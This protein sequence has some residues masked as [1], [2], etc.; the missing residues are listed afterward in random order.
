MIKLFLLLFRIK[1]EWIFLIFASILG[2][3]CLFL[4]PYGESPDEQSHFYRAYQIADGVFIPLKKGTSKQMQVG[5]EIP[6]SIAKTFSLIAIKGHP[7]HNQCKI[8]IKSYREALKLKLNPQEKYFDSSFLNTVLYSPIAYLPAAIGIKIGV[9][10]DF[11]P[12][13]IMYLGR[14]LNLFC[15][16]LIM[17]F[18]I[19]TTPILKH[20][21]LAISILP[22]IIFE[23]GASV[24][25]DAFLTCTSMFFLAYVWKLSYGTNVR[26]NVKV[27]RKKYINSFD[28]FI[29]TLTGSVIALIKSFY[30]PILLSVFLIPKKYFKNNKR[31]LLSI[32]VI[33]FV[34]LLLS[35][36]WN[37][38]A[39][40]FYIPAAPDIIPGLQ[41][42][43]MLAHPLIFFSHL[44]DTLKLHIITTSN[45]FH[46][47][48]GILGWL[49]IIFPEEVYSYALQI[50]LFLT[51]TDARLINNQNED[52]VNY[53]FNYK[54]KIKDKIK[55]KWRDKLF[56]FALFVG[57]IIL[58]HVVMYLSW[59]PVGS[60][61]IIIG[62]QCRYLYPF[63]ICS[64]FI[65]YNRISLF[66]FIGRINNLVAIL[67]ASSLIIKLIKV[68]FV[69]YF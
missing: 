63:A 18:A 68:L 1:V 24:S 43:Y 11:P 10:F 67:F 65:F 53:E 20:T 12:L 17:F 36:I 27:S 64:M 51:I 49:D 31:Y 3:I 15:Y 6:L 58:L 16:I 35:A 48:I 33:L 59:N 5:G 29:L 40:E 60:G 19:R 38:I 25:T 4:T 22:M 45:Y 32:S 57:M 37:S 47:F 8:D 21:M 7:M 52:K 46:Q 26:G 69:R 62:M 9:F 14:I 34:T 41:V 2:L 50:I 61:P 54:V 44:I 23:A 66:K 55:I 30:W 56:Y 39:K 13:I 28:I 42:K